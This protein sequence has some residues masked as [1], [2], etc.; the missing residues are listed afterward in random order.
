MKR[1]ESTKRY[2]RSIHDLEQTPEFA[3]AQNNEFAG[4]IDQE[5]TTTSRRRFI[6]L[7]GASVALA[8]AT[9][10]RWQEEKLLPLNDRNPGLTP[11]TPKNFSSIL[12][13][14]G[15]AVG[16]KVTSFDGRPTKIE[17]NPLHPESLGATST[18]AQA[19]T[20]GLYDPDRSR[21]VIHHDES[22]AVDK[23]AADFAAVTAG[24]AAKKGAGSGAVAVLAEPSASPSMLRMKESFLKA[25][26]QAT[27]VD[28]SPIARD[29]EVA[30]SK[31][32]FGLNARPYYRMSDAKI[33]VAL[34][35]DFLYEGPSALRLMREVTARRKPEA[36][37][38]N[39]IYSIEANYSLS[40]GFADHRLPLRSSEIGAFVKALRAKIS[41]GTAPTLSA[42]HADEMLTAIASDLKA[43]NGECVITCGPGQP[44]E[45][46]A[47]VAALN[48]ELGAKGKTVDYFK[49]QANGSGIDAV[50][51]LVAKMNAGTITDMVI[52]GGNPVY[53]MPADLD[54]G[55]ALDKVTN[56]VRLGLYLDETSTKC[57]W[58]APQAHELEIWTDG[59]APEGTVSIGQPLINPLWDGLGTTEIL[60][61]LI[62]AAQSS[63]EIVKQTSGLGS[64]AWRKALHDGIIAGSGAKPYR[65]KVKELPELATPMEG[66]ELRFIPHFVLRD[67][68]YA[69]LGWL[70]ELPDPMTKL[71][72][73]NAALI[74]FATAERLGVKHESLVELTVGGRKLEV[75]AYLMPGHADDSIT[76]ALG[77]GRTDG[78]HVA[79]LNDDDVETVGFDSYKLRGS[80]AMDVAAVSLTA[81]NKSYRLAT[82]QDHFAM[83]AIGT[84]GSQS[85]L[86]NLVKENTLDGY[87]HDSTFAKHAADFWGD[88]TTLWQELDSQKDTNHKWGMA[89]DLSSCTGCGSCTIACQSEN[90][91]SVVGKEQVLRGREMAWIR[92]DRYFLGDAE[93]PKAINQPINCA[94]CEL[95]PCE[96]VCP[97]AATTHSEEGL[98]DM[99]YNRCIGTRYCANNCPYKVRRFNYF[100]HNKD[101]ALPGNEVL[102]MAANPDVTVRDRGVMEKCT[103]C[104]QRIERTRIES[105]NENRDTFIEDGAIK[106]ACEQACPADA[107][108][109]GDLLDEDSRVLKAQ[110]QDRAYKLLVELNN[111]PRISFLARIRNPHPSL[112]AHEAAEEVVSH[113]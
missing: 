59:A 6:Q 35:D 79:G 51:D 21:T 63:Q 50:K 42:K 3:A 76:L 53:D 99:V 85:R 57:T 49:A 92:L 16:V 112:E 58:H 46:H 108:V 106:T 48:V 62:G 47:H 71:T 89:I 45:V 14:D 81:T 88:E 28:Y 61:R 104:V 68:R 33:I 31:I 113:G 69:N 17:G 24:I 29:N 9:S 97:V 60:A 103:F 111:K 40:G 36:G 101:A 94:H 87:E 83:D 56:S 18:F 38:M 34:D 22:N 11:G 82:T 7:M 39:R 43:N 84:E 96:S 72:W 86:P 41:G 15:F 37:W 91:I 67:G 20:L 12:D 10:C 98:N 66:L 25:F 13:S 109:F 65:V 32:A 70:Q 27:W 55:G 5:W 107:I 23:T 95:A 26:P 105:R 78:G 73:D 19:A 93:N 110:S 102:K 52:L 75:A 100:N 80:D 30:G 74:S 90:N 2:W 8:T 1:S 4:Q 54:F 64:T 44:A 77:F